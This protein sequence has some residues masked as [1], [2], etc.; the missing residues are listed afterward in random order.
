M[1]VNVLHRHVIGIINVVVEEIAVGINVTMIH[2][3][4]NVYKKCL[5]LNGFLDQKKDIMV[6]SFQVNASIFFFLKS[7]FTEKIALKLNCTLQMFFFS[8]SF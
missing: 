8:F 5:V 4:M 6:L 7:K 1:E 3:Q 2:L